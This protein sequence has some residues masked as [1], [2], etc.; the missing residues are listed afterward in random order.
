MPKGL[1]I[2]A[3][4]YS[5]VILKKKKKKKKKKTQIKTEKVVSQ[6]SPEKDPSFAWQCPHLPTPLSYCLIYSRTYQLIQVAIVVPVSVQ[7]RPC[8]LP[9][10]AHWKQIWDQGGFDFSYKL[11]PQQ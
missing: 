5:E 3:R 2:N 8:P 10:K 4:C 6:A 1:I 9:K 7:P 11:I